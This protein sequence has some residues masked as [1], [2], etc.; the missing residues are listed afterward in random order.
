MT[1]EQKPWRKLTRDEQID[2]VLEAYENGR[3]RAI[4]QA[5]V[6]AGRKRVAVAFAWIVGLSGGI[7]GVYNALSALFSKH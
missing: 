2:V 7:L 6:W 5:E 1:E 3:D 4:F